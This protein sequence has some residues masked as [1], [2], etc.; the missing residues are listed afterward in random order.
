MILDPR[1][2]PPLKAIYNYERDVVTIYVPH[3]VGEQTLAH[4]AGKV[5]DINDARALALPAGDRKDVA[6]R[7]SKA[8]RAGRFVQCVA[9]RG[10]VELFKSTQGTGKIISIGGM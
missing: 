7:T 2:A 5:A 3:A 4:V 10:E 8:C 1:K 9:T 6:E